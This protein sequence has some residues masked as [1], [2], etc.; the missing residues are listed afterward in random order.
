MVSA[1]SHPSLPLQ[2]SSI[3]GFLVL[4]LLISHG[5]KELFSPF[6]SCR[7]NKSVTAG[8]AR[9]APRRSDGRGV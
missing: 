6:L 1:L 3:F 5:D 4:Q 9:Q 8:D 7:G 2:P